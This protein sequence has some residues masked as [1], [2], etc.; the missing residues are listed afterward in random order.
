MKHHH[1]FLF[2][3]IL[4]SLPPLVSFHFYLPRHLSLLIFLNQP[5]QLSF[6]FSWNN[7]EWSRLWQFNLHYFDWARK[8]LSLYIETGSWP[9]ESFLL[10]KLIDNWILCNP[11]GHGDGWHSYT[12]SIRTRNWIHLFRI[13]PDLATSYRLKSLW[14]QLLWLQAHPERCHGGNHWLENLIALSFGG[15]YFTSSEAKYMFNRSFHLL[16][17]ELQDQLLSDGGHQERSSRLSYSY[18][19]SFN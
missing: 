6:P 8:W 1:I 4:N 16:K 19:R 7:S 12:I 17:F 15:L 5:L 11:P 14:H 9:T 3:P 2:N 13:C 18:P 10:E